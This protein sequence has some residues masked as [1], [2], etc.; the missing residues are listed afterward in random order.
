MSVDLAVS[1]PASRLI[2]SAQWQHVM[3][4][5]GFPFRLDP[6]DWA[7]QSGWLPVHHMGKLTGFELALDDIAE[8]L[9]G[10]TMSAPDAHDLLVMFRFG[11]DT[12]EFK[13]AMCAAAALA[14]AT[15]GV[16]HDPQDG[17]SYDAAAA[18]SWA[19]EALTKT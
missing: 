17:E 10:S 2:S 18:I 5:L 11:G 13:S 14:H 7:N 9:E 6:I 1:F 12:L 19:R 3:D 16:F 8:F 4:S 15:G